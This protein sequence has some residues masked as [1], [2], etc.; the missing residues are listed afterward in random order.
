MHTR[1]CIMKKVMEMKEKKPNIE[2]CRKEFDEVFQ[3][4]Y[5]KSL[6]DP[7]RIEIIRFLSFEGPSNISKIAEN[8]S[9]DRSVISRHLDLLYRNGVITKEKISRYTIYSVNLLNIIE[10]FQ[11]T[12]ENLKKHL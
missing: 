8:F 6:F 3:I 10:K 7:V 11:G 2:N 1:A 4:E 5:Y 9:Q 12:A